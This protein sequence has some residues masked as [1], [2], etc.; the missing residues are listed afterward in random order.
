[1][2]A[3]AGDRVRVQYT[4]IHKPEAASAPEP[5]PKV[6]EF[7]IGSQHA[8][9]GLSRHVAG[10]SQGEQKCI[11]LLP[12]EAFGHVQPRLIRELPRNCFRT[13]SP[14]KMGMVLN[15][16]IRGHEQRRKVRIIKLNPDTVTVDGN[17]PS[18]GRAVNL[19]VLVLSID[20]SSET[21]RSKPQF[22][23]G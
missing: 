13:K 19:A 12:A 4:R 8:L 7:T 22:D 20:S 17:H 23:N 21:N 15:A 2:S 16:K 14:L 3:K 9:P 5:I 6:L 11:S 10:M 1:M 18:A